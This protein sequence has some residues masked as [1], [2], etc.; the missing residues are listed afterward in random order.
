MVSESRNLP[1]FTAGS[2]VYAA[3][4]SYRV[5]THSSSSGDISPGRNFSATEEGTASRVIVINDSLKSQ[6]FGQSDPI[7]KQIQLG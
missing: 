7:G 4:R 3:R 1:G 5:G 6:L 2:A